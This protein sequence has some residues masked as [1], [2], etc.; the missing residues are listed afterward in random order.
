MRLKGPDMRHGERFGVTNYRPS[1]LRRV[2]RR[3]GDTAI[4]GGIFTVG[5]LWVLAILA[6]LAVPI[7][8]VWA[9]VRIVLKLT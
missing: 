2:Q 4:I 3:L 8:M 5:I 9:I 1:L 6:S 7:V